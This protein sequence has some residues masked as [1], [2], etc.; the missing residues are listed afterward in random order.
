VINQSEESDARVDNNEQDTD[1]VEERGMRGNVES[2][3]E[4]I[5]SPASYATTLSA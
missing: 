4:E 5:V 2:G 3:H 1:A